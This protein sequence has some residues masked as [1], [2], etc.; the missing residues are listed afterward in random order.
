MDGSVIF[1]VTKFD[2]TMKAK[3]RN[4]KK[5]ANYFTEKYSKLTLI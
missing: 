5:M 1:F 3:F 2:C 4:C